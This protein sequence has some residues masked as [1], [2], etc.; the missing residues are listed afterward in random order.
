[1]AESSSK[2]MVMKQLKYITLNDD[3]LFSWKAQFFAMLKDYRSMPYI[4]GKVKIVE[5]FAEEQHDQ[6]ILSWLLTSIS[7]SILPQVASLTTSTE[8]WESLH[9]MHT[10]VS[11]THLLHLRFQLQQIKKGDLTM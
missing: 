4:E 6:L 5:G 11:K 8:V 10:S 9:D 1:M 3:N 2:K 7:P